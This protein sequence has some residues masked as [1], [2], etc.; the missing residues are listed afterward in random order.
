MRKLC[1]LSAVLSV[2][3]LATASADNLVVEQA[4][5]SS[6]QI[7]I[8]KIG[9]ITFSESGLQVMDKNDS[10]IGSFSFSDI[11]RLMFDK[12]GGAAEINP[13]NALKFTKSGNTISVAGLE[14]ATDSYI[15]D[16]SGRVH[17]VIKSWN[18]SPADVSE[19]P[20]GV[21][22]AVVGNAAFKFLK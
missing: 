3:S 18:G 13:D 4:S 8:D 2:A 9:K 11:A 7:P 1:L 22:V 17:R 16:A 21:Y 10:Q 19:L 12:N 15:V 6:T 20:N 14:T 5:G